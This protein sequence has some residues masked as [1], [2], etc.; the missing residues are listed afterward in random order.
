MKN[1]GIVFFLIFSI[2]A[3]ARSPE[4]AQLSG[5]ATTVSTLVLPYDT[6]G[7]RQCLSIQNKGGVT[8]FAA[9][10]S[11]SSD[12]GVHIASGATYTWECGNAPRNAIYLKASSG[13]Q[14]YVI[15]YDL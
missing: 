3:F 2:S 10:A 9:Y 14:A 6:Y 4:K 15:D 8:I 13:G 7:N 11:Q 1:L 12:E 5:T